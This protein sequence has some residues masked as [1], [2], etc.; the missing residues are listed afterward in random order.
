M[1]IDK[2]DDA[3]MPL[4]LPLAETILRMLVFSK[5][6]SSGLSKAFKIFSAGFSNGD[7]KSRNWRQKPVYL[8]IDESGAFVANVSGEW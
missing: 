8:K 2:V 3:A 7:P 6:Q 4:P 5:S 1:Q